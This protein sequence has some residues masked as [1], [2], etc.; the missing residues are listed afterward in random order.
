MT[1]ATPAA[2]EAKAD[3]KLYRGYVLF[4]LVV[5]YTFNFIDRQIIGI[6][7]VPIQAE[8]GLS[9]R[10]LGLMGGIAFALFYSTLGVPIA[11]LA[12]RVNRTWIM[13][14]ALAA[15]SLMTAACGMVNNFWQL[16]AARLGV[17]VGEAGGV[18]PAYSL[19][20]DFFP[21]NQRARALAIYSFGIPIGSA[22]GIVF[23]GFVASWIDWR[24]AFII[25]GVAGLVLAP[26][27]KL[28][29]REPERGR[30]DPPRQTTERAKLGEVFAVLMKK[31]SFFLL[32]LGASCSS[33]MGYGIFFWLPSFFVR[34]FQV[35]IL[36]ASLL[37]GGILLVGGIIGVW[38]GGALGDKLGEKNRAAY[39]L[40]PAVAFLFTVPFY[41]L[42]VLSST[43]VVAILLFSV[44]VALGLM[45]LGPVLS[46]FQHLVRPDM[47][48]TASALF[49]LIN[50]LLGIGGGVYI[51]GEF[52][53]RLRPYFGD[54]SL[55]Y[56]ILA[57]SG[58]YL[59]AAILFF[60]A[61]RRLAKDWEGG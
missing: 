41:A 34:S 31:P 8:L 39:A 24:A 46:A 19:V 37:F 9:D 57:G 59:M 11:L 61:A 6:L 55:R 16:F 42:G 7:A 44:P 54:E 28:T 14:I 58:F 25:V 40:V 48:A 47:R 10:Q 38:A 56:S 13:T 36:E 21:P 12:D 17:G 49:L 26:I 43:P 20:A 22:V 29:V 50:N 4:I 60:F 45:W 2:A 1:A 51:L 30:F 18:A 33:M 23:G 27:F 35:D 32:T 5:V 3:S 52:S 15:W 53:E